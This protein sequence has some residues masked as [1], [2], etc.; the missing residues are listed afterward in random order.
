V[1]LRT[2]QAERLALGD[3]REWADLKHVARLHAQIRKPGEHG[4][5]DE[6]R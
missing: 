2:A 4:Q 5:Q 6:E 1:V 3:W